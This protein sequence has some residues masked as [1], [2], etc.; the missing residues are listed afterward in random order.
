MLAEAVEIG[1]EKSDSDDTTVLLVLGMP[2][3]LSEPKMLEAKGLKGLPE[4][5]EL[6]AADKPAVETVLTLVGLGVATEE[7]VGEFATEAGVVT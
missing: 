2:N 1:N 6:V 5:K 7:L 3:G 4:E